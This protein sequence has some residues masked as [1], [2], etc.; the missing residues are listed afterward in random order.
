MRSRNI[1]R[2]LVAPVMGTLPIG[3]VVFV[4]MIHFVGS[5][6]K[7]AAARRAGEIEDKERKRREMISSK[8]SDETVRRL[9]SEQKVWQGMNREQLIDSWGEPAGRSIRAL[10]TKTKETLSYG[11]RGWRS[12]VYLEGGVVVGWQQPGLTGVSEFLCAGRVQS[13]PP[14]GDRL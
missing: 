11:G 7:R 8:Y 9:S 1:P 4:G 6:Q 3:L 14:L 2:Y 12:R 5:Q 13:H 10:K